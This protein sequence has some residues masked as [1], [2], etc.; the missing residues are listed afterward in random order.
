MKE[1]KQNKSGGTQLQNSIEET[2]NNSNGSDTTAYRNH[3]DTV[4]RKLFSEKEKA[5][6]LYN[7]LK[8]TDYGPDT[9]V[10]FTTLDNAIYIDKK[11]D[12]GFIINQ[13]HIVISEHQSTISFNIPLRDVSYSGETFE[14]ITKNKNKYGK[15][16]VKIP[17]PEY[18]VIYTGEEEWKEEYI[19][20]SDY[21]MAEPPENSLELVVKIIKI[22]YTRENDILEK[23][24]TLKGYSMF[25]KY[26]NDYRQEGLDLTSAI[27][28]AI[29]RCIAED[30]IADFLIKEGRE[31]ASMIYDEITQEEF[32]EIRANEAAEEAFKEG[33]IKKQHE[34]AKAMKAK[35]MQVSIIAEVTGLTED[36]IKQLK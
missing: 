29:K 5:I 35:D 4:F 26:I 1:E 9:E 2:S 15:H 14:N 8:D 13:T 28:E 6:E 10:E 17:A 11:N 21:Y 32:A 3:K 23:S 16:G 31:V 30:Y 27:D 36:E 33:E 19:R 24:P 7:A 25:L 34:I 12:L 18:Y 20:L 22:G